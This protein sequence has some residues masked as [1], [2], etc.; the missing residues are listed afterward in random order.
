M[1]F[2]A[3]Q[4]IGR[5]RYKT[6]EGFLLCKDVPIARTG[7]QRYNAFEIQTIHPDAQGFI[8]ARRD[9]DQVFDPV[10]MASFEGKT[11]TDTHPSAAVDAD[12][13]SKLAKGH[14]QNVRRG[15]GI[16]ANLLIADFLV[17]DADL[18]GKI[19]RD[20]VREVSCGYDCD[21]D[22]IEPGLARQIKI[23]GN[24]VALVSKGRA[25]PVCAIQDEDSTMTASTAGAP[26]APV[27]LPRG[28]PVWLRRIG[29]ALR[30]NDAD[31]VETEMMDAAEM[32]EKLQKDNADLT[33]QMAAK[34]AEIEELK[35]KADANDEDPSNV[36]GPV[37]ENGGVLMT[38]DAMTALL[39]QVEILASGVKLATNDA[40]KPTAAA[41][42]GLK[43]RV[44][45]VAAGKNEDV[46]LLLNGK[47]LAKMT[48]DALAATFD[49]AHALV[50]AANNAKLKPNTGTRATLDAAVQ[51]ADSINAKARAHWGKAKTVA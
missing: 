36:S 35:K 16:D 41:A 17:K 43:R 33:S 24:H 37:L 39:A 27:A 13:W 21:Y 26:A 44:L 19:E 22:E 34:D 9:E 28:L 49:G 45:E 23:R 25:G 2:A 29:N 10:A 5:T 30:M 14:L 51:D 48:T 7:E 46:K 40:A 11:I 6:P 50:V 20:E 15:A 12:T 18:I 32:V 3:S 8:V 4:Q 47:D 42:D 38:G 1:F 31:T